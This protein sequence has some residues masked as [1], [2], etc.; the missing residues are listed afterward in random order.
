MSERGRATW[1]REDALRYVAI[2]DSTVE[3][4]EDPGPDGVYVGWADRLAHHL[5]RVSPGLTYAN[6]A[7][8]GMTAREVRTTQLDRALALR[9]DVAVVVAGVNDVLRPRFDKEALRD[10]L[11]AMHA[12]LHD[13]GASVAAFTMPD[14][15]KVAP[16]AV[17]L[18]GRLDALNEIVLEAA[19]LYGT[20]V[21]DLAA[22][23]L[24]SDPALWH[25][26]R[27][28][29]HSEGHRRVALALAAS[30]GVDAGD[31]RTPRPL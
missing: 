13:A 19:D 16:L 2:G 14:M 15:A 4:L 20:A 10:D 28:H 21:A 27:L 26:D 30:L 7:V 29:A 17:V 5:S 23:P 18:R 8:R 1:G 22:E 9:P 24:S 25:D 31:W 6:L 12:A 11:L 3:G